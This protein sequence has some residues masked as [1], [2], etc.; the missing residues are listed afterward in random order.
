MTPYE[1]FIKAY[2]KAISGCI[3]SQYNEAQTYFAV[4]RSAIEDEFMYQYMFASDE[5]IVGLIMTYEC[6]DR[7]DDV[8]E[9]KHFYAKSG[10]KFYDLKD[11]ISR[12]EYLGDR[13]N[14]NESD[15]AAIVA[16]QVFIEL[17]SLTD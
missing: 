14:P 11:E 10:S 15:I 4:I 16:L 7:V 3:T 13:L 5:V 8:Y 2:Q 17:S 9:V 6:H 12:F 1:L